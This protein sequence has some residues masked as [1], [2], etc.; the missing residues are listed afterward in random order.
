MKTNKTLKL[1]R[2][3]YA[4]KN[5]P[6]EDREYHLIGRNFP[7]GTI[8]EWKDF[9]GKNGFDAVEVEETLYLISEEEIRKKS[10]ELGFIDNPV[11]CVECGNQI[12]ENDKQVFSSENVCGSCKTFHS[13]EN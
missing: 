11:S 13:G 8:A 1:E 4:D 12:T 2:V 3:S 6:V 5:C 10:A 9:A 7:V